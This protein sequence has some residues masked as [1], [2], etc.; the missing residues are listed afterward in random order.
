MMNKKI[1]VLGSTGMLGNAVFRFLSTNQQFQVF[2]TMRHTQDKRFFETE[3]HDHIITNVDVLNND[4]LMDVF[5]EVN[6][7]IVIN[8]IGLIKQHAIAKDPLITLPINAMLPHRLVKLCTLSAARLIHIS[9]DCVFSG[10]KG[11]YKETDLSDAEDLYGKSKF[12]GEL[13]DLTNAVTL[14]TSIIGHELNSNYALIDWFLS[15]QGSIKGY[16]KAIFSG[17]PTIELAR[18]I[19]EFVIPNDNLS[20][21][22]HVSADPIDKFSLLKL[23]AETYGKVI[24]IIPDEQLC[25]DRS[26]DSTRFKVA[27]GYIPPSW[28]DLILKMKAFNRLNLDTKSHV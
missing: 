25:I 12:I 19:A 18:V 5:A 6:P 26:L 22:Y 16:K 21:L 15:Q 4:A 14:R 9:T 7:D 11:M 20:G 13:N 17:L 24:D 23:V 10:R 8:C 28:P 2:A 3:L 27:S 1:L